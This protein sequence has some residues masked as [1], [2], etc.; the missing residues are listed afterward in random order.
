MASDSKMDA[1]G[2]HPQKSL[3]YS[4][5]LII[6]RRQR[7]L[8]EVR[9]M[10]AEGGLEK[11]SVRK[12][13]AEAGVAPRTLYNAFHN[14][15]RVIALAIREAYDDFNNYVRYKT[16]ANS[17]AGVLDRTIAINERNF[18]VRNYTAAVTAIYFGP[19]TPRDVWETLRHMSLNHI[20][21][22]METVRESGCL[23]AGINIE[24]FA[25]TMANVQYST[26]NDWCLGRIADEQYLLR[27]TENMLLLT[28]GS[29][30]GAVHDEAKGYLSKMQVSQKVPSFPKAVWAP[31]IDP[32]TS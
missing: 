1:L 11:F 31:K 24:H 12:L 8:K 3:L 20:R 16:D 28:L 18:R 25:D 9:H 6:E 14:K 2:A 7:L 26:I 15:D 10:I 5:P 21:P 32:E 4:S 17:L 13:C 30:V 29:V 23:Q 19:N 27:L 22:W